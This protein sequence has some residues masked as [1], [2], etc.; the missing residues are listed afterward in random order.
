MIEQVST[1]QSSVE[2]ARKYPMDVAIV[3]PP[4]E[5]PRFGR[6]FHCARFRYSH[7]GDL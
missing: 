1:G 6:T 4:E 5:R 2:R 3:F 7:G